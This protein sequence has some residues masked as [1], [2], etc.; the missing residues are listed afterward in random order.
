MRKAVFVLIALALAWSF[1]STLEPLSAQEVTSSQ[2]LQEGTW[3]G[4]LRGIG[5]RG[6]QD[7]IFE[8]KRIPDPHA[9]W[10]SGTG[11]VLSVTLLPQQGRGSRRGPMPLSDVRLQGETLSYRVT[12][13]KLDCSL[14]RQADGNFA[15]ECVNEEDEGQILQLTM[16][17]PTG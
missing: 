1:S 17:R 5:N 4:T 13:L 8:V 14:M 15:G 11:E 12:I 3:S 6:P 10:R 9:R 16:I 2:E 7:L